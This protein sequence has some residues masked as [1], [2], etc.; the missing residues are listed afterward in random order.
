MKVNAY[1]VYDIKVQI[2]QHLFYAPNHS[3]AIR[4][5]HSVIRNTNTPLGEYPGDY[6]L[7][8]I[9]EWNDETAVLTP[10]SGLYTVINGQEVLDRYAAMDN[11][12]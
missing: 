9:G 7:V 6:N 4:S 8:H 1:C 5:F 10:L 11:K 2:Y 12:E 3:V